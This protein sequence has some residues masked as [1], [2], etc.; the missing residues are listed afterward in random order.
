MALAAISVRRRV[1]RGSHCFDATLRRRGAARGAPRRSREAGAASGLRWELEMPGRDQ[2]SS[3]PSEGSPAV[4]GGARRLEAR[5]KMRFVYPLLSLQRPLLDSESASQ[6]AACSRAAPL[7]ATTRTV[8]P[9]RGTSHTA[10]AARAQ[11]AHKGSLSQ[12]RERGYRTAPCPARSPSAGPTSRAARRSG[13]AGAA[14]NSRRLYNRAGGAR[15]SSAARW[16][17]PR[18]SATPATVLVDTAS[19][20]TGPTSPA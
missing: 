20:S 4:P 2:R 3:E 16:P 17:T 11:Q 18:A 8:R 13:S 15:R 14:T 10:R 9:R 5:K 6:R 7:R 12:Q 1:A 19:P